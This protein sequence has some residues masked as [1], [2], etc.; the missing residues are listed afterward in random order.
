MV[1][2]AFREITNSTSLRVAMAHRVP[3]V[4]PSLPALAAVPRAP[5]SGASPTTWPTRPR[6]AGVAA[7][8]DD[9]RASVRDAAVGWLSA[10]DW[11]RVAATTREVSER[12]FARRRPRRQR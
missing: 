8:T 7:A 6:D 1:V 4:L 9:E 10:W 3:C 2:F 5:R 11:D 12:S